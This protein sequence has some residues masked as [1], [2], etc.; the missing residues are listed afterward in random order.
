MGQTLLLLPMR[1]R[2]SLISF[3]LLTCWVLTTQEGMSQRVNVFPQA[4]D[5]VL[6]LIDNLPTRI[7]VGEKG[8]NQVWD[9]TFLQ[10][11]FVRKY[12]FEQVG[13]EDELRIYRS[14]AEFQYV[15]RNG[16]FYL[17]KI[18]SADPLLI[19]SEMTLTC[20]PALLEYKNPI[21]YNT[22]TSTYSRLIGYLPWSEIPDQFRLTEYDNNDSMRVI[23]E[24]YRDDV[25]DA[26]GS[27][28]M[29]ND[30]FEVVRE[31]RVE[32][33]VLTLW[34]KEEG[35]WIDITE[36]LKPKLKEVAWNSVTYS[37]L[38]LA[39]GYP[40]PIA[41]VYVDEND[42]VQQVIYGINE[43]MSKEIATGHRLRGV[44]VYPNP[45]LGNVRFEFF[46]I[47]TGDYSLIVYNM[48]GQEKW[49]R[50]VAVESGSVVRA[51]L[52]ELDRGT[53]FYSLIDSN[54]KRLFTRRIVIF[55]P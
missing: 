29:K 7:D 53:Y 28:L 54:G 38:Y 9:F 32:E 30:L 17:T 3:V 18:L 19:G 8:P 34:A 51:D 47:P 12:A 1:K 25:A 36:I 13:S 46:N 31:Q 41:E 39:D 4:R 50:P 35:R 44:Y 11:P 52:T 49:Q 24:I 5:T 40:S 33:Q 23:L 21:T 2:L 20:A 16:N 37:Y 43:Y 48:L 55:K 10:S 45:T 27:L 22:A 6:S 15:Q 42:E 26:Y 14:D